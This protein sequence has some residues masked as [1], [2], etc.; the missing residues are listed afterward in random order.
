MTQVPSPVLQALSEILAAQ[1]PQ[2][3]ARLKQRLTAALQARGEPAFEEKKFG[4]KGFRDFLERGTQGLFSIQPSAE[5]ADVEVSLTGAKSQ[6]AQALPPVSGGTHSI[7]NEVW[8]A[9]TNPDSSRLRYLSRRNF[10][11]RH[12]LRGEDSPHSREVLESPDDFVEIQPIS[13]ETQVAWMRQFVG[14][15][16][17]PPT[18]RDAIDAIVDRPYSSGV[19]AAFTGALGALGAQWRQVRI[20]KVIDEIHAWAGAHGIPPERLSLRSTAETDTTSITSVVDRAVRP[21]HANDGIQDPRERAVRL[22]E[23]LSN[24]DISRVVLPIL[25]STLLVKGKI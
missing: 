12:F 20:K 3:A 16:E 10:L 24:E 11:V 18:L 1:S 14:A 4:F 25:L 17:I 13:A 9:F 6:S 2:F 15:H 5:G 7:R 19:N 21:E 23:M 8:Q 22:L